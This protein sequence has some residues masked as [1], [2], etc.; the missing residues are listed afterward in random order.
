MCFPSMNFSLSWTN[1][2]RVE[3]DPAKTKDARA[4]KCTCSEIIA[5]Q[6]RHCELSCCTD[7]ESTYSSSTDTAYP[8][9]CNWFFHSWRSRGL[10][11]LLLTPCSRIIIRSSCSIKCNDNWEKV[12]FSCVP[13]YG[14]GRPFVPEWGL[15]EPFLHNIFYYI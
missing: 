12:P 8:F 6:T 5:S 7:V 3:Q 1:K 14:S 11:M 10:L 9:Y 15:S 2:T 4:E 13:F